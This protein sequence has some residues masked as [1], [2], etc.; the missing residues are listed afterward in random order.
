MTVHLFPHYFPLFSLLANHFSLFFVP[1]TKVLPQADQISIKNLHSLYIHDLFFYNEGILIY[2][3]DYKENQVDQMIQCSIKHISIHQNQFLT[4]VSAYIRQ[5]HVFP[6]ICLFYSRTL[7]TFP[8]MIL[9]YLRSPPVLSFY[10][11]WTL[12]LILMN[13]PKTFPFFPSKISK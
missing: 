2:I 10:L 5:H 3:E 13:K 8:S 9:I 4:T 1:S 7:W 11:L 6:S 12:T